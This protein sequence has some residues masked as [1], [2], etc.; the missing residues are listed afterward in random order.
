[1]PTTTLDAD[2]RVG[3]LWAAQKRLL[4][5]ALKDGR[6]LTPPEKREVEALD[7]Q[8]DAAIAE[9]DASRPDPLSECIRLLELSSGERGATNRVRAD[10][11]AARAQVAQQHADTDD[12]TVRALLDAAEGRSGDDAADLYKQ[13]QRHI[14]R[15]PLVA[16]VN[17]FR[18]S[19]SMNVNPDRAPG[20][21]VT[22]V[23]ISTLIERARD[24]GG[25]SV[26]VPYS[27]TEARSISSGTATVP[28]SFV[29]SMAVYEREAA[30]AFS[31][32]DVLTRPYGRDVILPRLT[33][34]V[35]AVSTAT[36]ELGG[37]TLDDV[38]I[39]S[40]T[41][42][43]FKAAVIEVVSNELVRDTGIAELENELAMSLGRAI[44][45]RVNNWATLGTGTVEPYGLASRATLGG[46]AQG[47]AFDSSVSG[48]NFYSWGD[49]VDLQGY[50]P[51]GILPRA[52]YMT[53]PGGIRAAMK[54]RDNTGQPIF[55]PFA[56]YMAGRNAN[57]SPVGTLWGYPVWLN[58]DVPT[59]GSAVAG[60]YFGDMKAMKLV[61]VGGLRLD[62]SREFKFGN[63][64][65]SI[66][67]IREVASDLPDVTAIAYQTAADT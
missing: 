59:P 27:T 56:D 65:Y 4:D 51:A 15:A 17:T 28:D 9:R 20:R 46:T 7:E 52:A 6:A 8:L 53:S 45:Y 18:G 11:A 39:S 32:F 12:P 64:G 48:G 41:A 16:A 19:L 60:W 50:V 22:P 37:I 67:A 24:Y 25:V 3:T 49:V 10:L 21:D 2:A 66:R 26:E 55:Q 1:M 61:D 35:T 62:V 58:S 29:A 5:A 13:L 38:T 57:T 54:W 42:T 33:A 43:V 40:V 31:A 14:E 44:A 34:D 36:A 23:R 63:D 30:P 47:T